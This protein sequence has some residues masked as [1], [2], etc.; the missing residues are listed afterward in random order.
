M[1][2]RKLKFPFTLNQGTGLSISNTGVDFDGTTPLT[3]EIGVGNDISTTGKPQFS[4]VTSSTMLLG[5]TTIRNYGIDPNFSF[6][7]TVT[8]DGNFNIEGNATIGGRVTAEEFIA[9][10]SSSSTLFKY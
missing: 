4:A 5:S 8:V 9:E 10:L 3:Y 7:G 6:S 1:P 2:A